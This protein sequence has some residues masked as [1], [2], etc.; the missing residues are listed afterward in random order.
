[1]HLNKYIAWRIPNNETIFQVYLRVP[2]GFTPFRSALPVT[3]DP[4][5][6]RVVEEFHFDPRGHRVHEKKR[7]HGHRH[8]HRHGHRHKHKKPKESSSEEVIVLPPVETPRQLP[9]SKAFLEQEAN[10]RS[11]HGEP[12][13]F[14]DVSPVHSSSTDSPVFLHRLPDLPEPPKCPG[15]PWKPKRVPEPVDTFFSDFDLS[16]ALQ[17]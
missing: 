14:P 11:P 8:R 2:P 4:E 3:N 7:R 15:T 12:V 10:S 5:G 1:M 6:P 17:D 16:D 9:T 13:G